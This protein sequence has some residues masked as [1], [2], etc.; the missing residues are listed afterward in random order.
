LFIFEI[1]LH[2]FFLGDSVE[3]QFGQLKVSL[4][5]K[6]CFWGE[7]GLHYDFLTYFL[8]ERSRALRAPCILF[9]LIS[10]LYEELYCNIFSTMFSI[11][12]H[13]LQF[14]ILHYNKCN[15]FTKQR[16]YNASNIL[17]Y[18]FAVVFNAKI[19][20][21]DLYVLFCEFVSYNLL[22]IKGALSD[23]FISYLSAIS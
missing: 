16:F 2:K 10:L 22:Y 12:Q 18:I 4:V 17:A 3:K 19:Y 21:Q 7:K 8:G 15:L 11:K 9:S 1:I 23:L 14:Q 6:V 13:L 20:F 5:F